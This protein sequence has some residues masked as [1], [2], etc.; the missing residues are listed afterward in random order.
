M[1]LSPH[2]P[3]DDFEIGDLVKL[4]ALGKKRKVASIKIRGVVTGHDRYGCVLVNISKKG[5]R[6]KRIWPFRPE[7]IERRNK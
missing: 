1:K 7:F 2:R 3:L 5:K 4:S 6:L